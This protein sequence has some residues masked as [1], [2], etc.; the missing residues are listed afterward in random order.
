MTETTV[1]T[2]HTCTVI[3]PD[4]SA[5][6]RR[7]AI[8]EN[9]QNAMPAFDALPPS[10]QADSPLRLAL[11][12]AKKW[13]TGRTLRVRFLDGDPRVHKKIEAYAHQWSRHANIKFKFGSDPNAEIR[14]SCRLGEGSWS[15]LGTDALNIPKNKPTMNY[16]WLTPNSSDDE[17][18]RVVLHEFG[19]AL[20]C[21][22]EHQHP[23]S[24][25]PWNKEAVYR[26]YMGPPNNWSKEQVDRN[27][28]RTLDR[29]STQ[30]SKFDTQSIMIYPVPNELTL[31][32]FEV[33]WNRHLSTRDKQFM[34]KVYPPTQ[35]LTGTCQ[36]ESKH[37]G[38]VLDIPSSSTEDGVN[39]IQW[40]L[41]D[42][43]N[44]KWIL[45][46]AE[47]GYYYIKSKLSGK[48]LDVPGS[49]T[50]DGVGII[51]WSLTGGDN[52]NWNLENV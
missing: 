25:I 1:A 52:Q 30:F 15:Y 33:G 3:P 40:S 27:L 35:G 17:Y 23:E 37:S 2:I 47:A 44:Q 26:K 9:P 5:E 29:G 13:R 6:A 8:E 14:I 50:E 31:G 38:K 4:L 22:H 49:S 32:N 45:E 42:G 18:S 20:G 51:Q 48:V 43:D 21:I 16:G 36:I 24:G 39:I 46:K 7:L 11:T 12:T 28:F 19:H 10:A 41:T 34:R